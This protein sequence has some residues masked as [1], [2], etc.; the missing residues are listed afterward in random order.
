MINVFQIKQLAA[1]ILCAA[2]G[3]VISG[4]ITKEH[5]EKIVNEE[6]KSIR[7]VHDRKVT[8]LQK[9]LDMK[10]YKDILITNEYSPEEKNTCPP[11]DVFRKPYLIPM[12]TFDDADPTFQK[13]S[14]DYYTEDKVLIENDE[15]VDPHESIGMDNLDRFAKRMDLI[16]MYVRNENIGVDYEVTK[17]IAKWNE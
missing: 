9:E 3:A 2:G 5:Y 1:C 11:D 17:I 4:Y 16:M 15:I 13:V 8:N 14:L 12:E 6:V 7:E 10:N